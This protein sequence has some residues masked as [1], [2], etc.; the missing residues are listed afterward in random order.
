MDYITDERYNKLFKK[1]ENGVK[2]PKKFYSLYRRLVRSFVWDDFPAFQAL[3]KDTNKEIEEEGI[4][5]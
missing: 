1:M 3:E 4:K 5:N 2:D